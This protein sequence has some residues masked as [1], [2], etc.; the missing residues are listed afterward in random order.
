MSAMLGKIKAWGLEIGKDPALINPVLQI[1]NIGKPPLY[2]E[3]QSE[4]QFWSLK[5][6][7][8]CVV[9]SCTFYVPRFIKVEAV[10]VARATKNLFKTRSTSD[11]ATRE[12]IWSKVRQN[13]HYFVWSHPLLY[14]ACI[15]R[16]AA[17]VLHPGLSI[18]T[19]EEMP[20]FDWE[21]LENPYDSPKSKFE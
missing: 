20:D 14:T 13:V 18:G 5:G 6:R 21:D 16:L 10:A 17:G 7:I 19:K 3:D 12:R 2:T 15:V 9:M 8:K 4:R 1:K 11:T